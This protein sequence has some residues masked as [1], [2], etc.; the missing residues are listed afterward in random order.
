MTTHGTR[1]TLLIN[2]KQATFLKKLGASRDIDLVL[3]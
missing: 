1:L 3:I 2:E